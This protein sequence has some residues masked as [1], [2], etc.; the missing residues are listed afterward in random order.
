MDELLNGLFYNKMSFPVNFRKFWENGNPTVK[1]DPG[2]FIEGP[3]K[4]LKTFHFLGYVQK[5]LQVSSLVQEDE[6]TFIENDRLDIGSKC[7]VNSFEKIIESIHEEPQEEVKSESIDFEGL[8]KL[9][10]DKLE[11]ICKNNNINIPDELL[12]ESKYMKRKWALI[13]LIKTHFGV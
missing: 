3:I 6:K 10:N 13:K 7:I 11:D 9:K 5:N 8:S 2:D 12:S 1:M 4:Y